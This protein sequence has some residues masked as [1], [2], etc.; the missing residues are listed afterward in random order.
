MALLF[1][2]N[3]SSG[4]AF[5][6]RELTADE[7]AF[8]AAALEKVVSSRSRRRCST[9]PVEQVQRKRR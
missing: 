9:L 5:V 1:L 2:L 6:A 7:E 3:P 8:S 4:T